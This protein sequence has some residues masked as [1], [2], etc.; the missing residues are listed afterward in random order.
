MTLPSIPPS[1]ATNYSTS[2]II[3]INTKQE[4]I[5]Q[6]LP[7]TERKYNRKAIT[8]FKTI[9]KHHNHNKSIA[10]L[11]LNNL[12]KNLKY[13]LKKI[14]KHCTINN[15]IVKILN[16]Q[17]VFYNRLIVFL[18]NID[19]NMTE[20]GFSD[21][22]RIKVEKTINLILTG[23]KFDLLNDIGRELNHIEQSYQSGYWIPSP[24]N[25]SLFD[26]DHENR[27]AQ[28]YSGDFCPKWMKEAEIIP[29]I[30][31]STATLAYW[32]FRHSEINIDR[33]QLNDNLINDKDPVLYRW[34]C[35]L[36][37]LKT[38][39]HNPDTDAPSSP[40][41]LTR[42]HIEA[43]AAR[44]DYADKIANAE[45][46]I[47][48]DYMYYRWYG[49]TP[50]PQKWIKQKHNPKDQEL[51]DND[52]V[53][54]PPRRSKR[55]STS[56]SSSVDSKLSR[57]DKGNLFKKTG[58]PE[59]EE[60]IKSVLEEEEQRLVPGSGFT[61]I[62]EDNSE[63]SYHKRRAEVIA[64]QDELSR[65]YDAC[66]RHCGI[67]KSCFKDNISNS[68]SK[69]KFSDAQNA[70]I[71]LIEKAR[72]LS[73][74]SAMKSKKMQGHPED[75]GDAPAWQPLTSVLKFP[76]P[77]LT[78]LF[79]IKGN[80]YSGTTVKERVPVLVKEIQNTIRKYRYK[81]DVWS[82]DIAREALSPSIQK[83]RE[84]QIFLAEKLNDCERK[85][86]D[87]FISSHHT[88]DDIRTAEEQRKQI[89]E[90]LEKTAIALASLEAFSAYLKS[91][92]HQELYKHLLK[93]VEEWRSCIS[94]TSERLL[95]C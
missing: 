31:A 77:F 22:D 66:R 58:I 63:T 18:K 57:M 1:P 53:V 32:N 56:L 13:E 41:N 39:F 6:Y 35:E 47:N 93:A 9:K 33:G 24:E 75:V 49:D 74:K 69:P 54:I 90:A 10:E 65:L 91:D 71:I 19:H 5:K 84:F 92:K 72:E 73:L 68:G 43:I 25:S 14:Q 52:E 42:F 11:Y 30:P 17:G 88:K 44:L 50:C 15:N 61:I 83:V 38:A 36:R 26:Q 87:P 78:R 27:D 59:L 76:M 89:R 23:G 46:K 12:P 40:L 62:L 60:V 3:Q 48:S 86:Q 28:N 8:E 82:P 21:R 37:K 16:G 80:T 64:A 7:E 94:D 34:I 79:A 85:Q 55:K 95:F 20:N 45:A 2:E 70:L 67:Q 51:A 81:S 4:E 29:D